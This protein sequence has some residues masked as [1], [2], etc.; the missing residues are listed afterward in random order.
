MNKVSGLMIAFTLCAHAVLASS[1]SI[2]W[3]ADLFGEK[4]RGTGLWSLTLPTAGGEPG[5]SPAAPLGYAGTATLASLPAG[6]AMLYYNE[7][8]YSHSSWLLGMHREYMGV[9]I[10]T[11]AAGVFGIHSSFFSTSSSPQAYTLKDSLQKISLYEYTAGGTWAG[12]MLDEKVSIGGTVSYAGSILESKS[13]GAAIFGAEALFS[14]W[15]RF[16]MRAYARNISAGSI[17]APLQYGA[18]FRVVAV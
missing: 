15:S 13:A 6:A 11:N 8:S 5:T 14:P 1:D 16:D 10:P 4:T 2:D 7:F 9:S 18:A 12:S 3:R 17:R